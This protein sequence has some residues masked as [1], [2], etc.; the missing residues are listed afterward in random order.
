MTDLLE[1]RNLGV[2]FSEHADA[3]RAVDGVSFTLKPGEK[4]AL[5]G[6]SGSGKSVTALSLLRLVANARSSGEVL[7]DGEDLVSASE[8]R[9]RGIRGKDIAM[10]FQ[11]PMTALN[12]LMRIGEQIVEVLS[13]H[14]GMDYAPARARTIELLGHTGITEPERRFSSYPHELSG[15]QRQ[16]AMIA[17]A[18]ACRPKLL[19][20]DEPTTALDVTIR[21]QIMELLDALQR[22]YGMAILLIT[23]DLNLVRRFADRVGVMQSGRLVELAE[24]GQLFSAPQHPYTQRLLDSRPRKMVQPLSAEQETGTDLLRGDDLRVE[25]SY[26]VGWFK[27]KIFTAVDGVSL[28]LKRGET[29]GIVGESGSG[30]ST[31]AMALL[32][33]QPL[34]AGNCQFDGLA[35]PR[36]QS[37]K[38]R[39]MRAKMQVVFQDPF[40]SLSPRMTIEQIVGEG[41]ALHQPN[42][43]LAER[44]RRIAQTLQ[45]VGLGADVLVRYPHEFSGGQRQ[46]IAIA[47]AIILEPQLLVL[48]EPTS[49]LDASV[50]KQV[51]ELLAGLQTRHGMSY[52]LISHDLEVIAAMSHRIAVMQAGRIV[53]QG[54]AETIINTP[55][56]DY[57]RQLLASVSPQG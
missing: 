48:D 31:L 35:V 18:L 22:E 44:R 37:A 1:V 10:I 26:P 11:E 9:L 5:V 46:R 51:L 25:F 27:K 7:F 16:R 28:N 13:L 36:T 38:L 21:V 47:R 20:A 45:E 34:T 8:R 42:M 43:P 14:E 56:H 23:H 15:G 3:P 29:L 12:P 19:I 52:L 57:T 6:E 49:A 24:T 32:A 40:G 39:A 33:L 50:Q 55:Q 53:E 54:D 30:K 17:M 41:L 4:F 2:S